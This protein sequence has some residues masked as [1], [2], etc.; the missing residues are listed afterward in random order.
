MKIEWH[1]D[2]WDGDLGIYINDCG[3]GWVDAHVG[4]GYSVQCM[5][6]AA[7]DD[8]RVKSGQLSATDYPEDHV[9]ATPDE[10]KQAL[11]DHAIAVYIGGWRTR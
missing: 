9:F 11:L 4:G 7:D 2:S 1:E 3:M 6:M 5:W 10:A 8:A